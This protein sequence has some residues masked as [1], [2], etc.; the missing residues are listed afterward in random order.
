MQKKKRLIYEKNAFGPLNFLEVGHGFG[1]VS[2]SQCKEGN[3][4]IA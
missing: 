2:S 4:I 3:V 1:S